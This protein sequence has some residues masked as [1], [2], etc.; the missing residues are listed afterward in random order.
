MRRPW[1][2]TVVVDP[3]IRRRLRR[4]KSRQVSRHGQAY[5]KCSTMGARSVRPRRRSSRAAR[6]TSRPAPRRGHW[7]ARIPA[8]PG[9]ARR[10][11][12]RT[13]GGA[14]WPQT[15]SNWSR[16]MASPLLQFF[17]PILHVAAAA[18][19]ARVGGGQEP[20]LHS[21]A[22]G[23]RRVKFQVRS[24]REDGQRVRAGACADLQ[25]IRSVPTAKSSQYMMLPGVSILA[26]G[27]DRPKSE[28]SSYC[29]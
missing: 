17:Q 22:E 14:G 25:P 16:S 29:P 9:T 2:S 10:P 4:A 20:R 24:A 28:N 3:A 15:A 21:R 19:Q 23:C 1:A 26:I 11:R 8:A 13:A 5:G 27:S 12:R 6:T 18:V 7:R